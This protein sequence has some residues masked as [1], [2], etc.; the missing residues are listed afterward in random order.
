MES[1]IYTLCAEQG[2]NLSGGQRT[3]LS[4]A[5]CFY[6]NSEIFL[7]DDPLKALDN[8][9]AK[10]IMERALNDKFKDKTRVVTSSIASHAS[11]ADRV[12]IMEKGEIIFNGVYEEAIKTEYFKRVK[13][14]MRVDTTMPVEMEEL[15]TLDSET[16]LSVDYDKVFM[17]HLEDS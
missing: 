4:L 9:T 5:R 8:E 14:T 6:Q 1:G 15:E 3:R 13:K 17:E 2:R 12:L 11:Y 7:L 16:R 10:N